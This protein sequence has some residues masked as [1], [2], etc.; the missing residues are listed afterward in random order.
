[1]GI[2][3]SPTCVLAI[4]DGEGAEGYLVGSLHQGLPCM[5]TMMNYMRLGVGLHALG[6]AERSYQIAR[7]YAADRVQGRNAQ[8]QPTVILGHA[9]VR[10]MLL[11]MKALLQASRGL[12]YTAAAALD[13]AQYGDG[14]AAEA[15]NERAELLTPIVK[16]WCSDMAIEVTSLGVQVL[17][18]MGFVEDA[19]AAQCYRDVRITAIYEGTNGIQGQDLLGRKVLRDGGRALTRPIP[20]FSLWELLCGVR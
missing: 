11:T 14:A 1:M 16:S 12:A 9:D 8:G 5:F 6:I 20:A 7:R 3:A 4:G 13:V 18:G 17:G 2:H 19:G 10:R 15:A